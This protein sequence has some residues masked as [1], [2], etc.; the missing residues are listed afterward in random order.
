MMSEYEYY[1]R[2]PVL[3]IGMGALLLLTM[4]NINTI[5]ILRKIV[6]RK[7]ISRKTYNEGNEIHE[8]E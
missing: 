7:T 6:K 4:A 5:I 1:D 2:A 3:F 8:A